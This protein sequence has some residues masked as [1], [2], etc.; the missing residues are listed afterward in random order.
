MPFFFIAF[1]IMLIVVTSLNAVSDGRR[2]AKEYE[3]TEVK[4]YRD[5]ISTNDTI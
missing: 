1:G 5:A 2:K 3:P 4:T